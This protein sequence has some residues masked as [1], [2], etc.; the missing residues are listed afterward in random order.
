MWL[1]PVADEK[2]V[3]E[4][5]EGTL[6]SYE[7]AGKL[8]THYVSC[9]VSRNELELIEIHQF[10]PKCGTSVMGK[11]RDTPAGRQIGINVSPFIVHKIMYLTISRSE[12]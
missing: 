2:L 5:G 9:K 1:W 12:C 3:V 8:M 4:S 10:C 11:R 6:Q 7:F